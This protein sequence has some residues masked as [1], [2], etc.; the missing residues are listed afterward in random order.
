M[1][2]NETLATSCDLNCLIEQRV[3]EGKSAPEVISDKL[4]E[5]QGRNEE[6]GEE[7]QPTNCSI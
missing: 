6:E 4:R 5:M 2:E 3:E 7:N 1:G